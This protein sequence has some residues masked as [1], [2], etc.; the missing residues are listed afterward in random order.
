MIKPNKSV[1][2]QSFIFL[3]VEHSSLFRID[4]ISDTG[5]LTKGSRTLKWFMNGQ[6]R[7]LD[8]RIYK[9]YIQDFS[10]DKSTA[11]HDNKKFIVEKK[12]LT[13]CT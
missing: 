13:S 8:S 10:E 12:V 6:Q 2:T 4:L 9:L 7:V 3:F 1:G 11:L 5:R